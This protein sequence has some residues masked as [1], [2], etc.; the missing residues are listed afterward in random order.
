MYYL[1]QLKRERIKELNIV[2]KV[3]ATSKCLTNSTS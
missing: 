3:Q 1:L 2:H